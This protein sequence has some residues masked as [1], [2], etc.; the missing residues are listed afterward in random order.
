M[1]VVKWNVF[2]NL[3]WLAQNWHSKEVICDKDTQKLPFEEIIW[4]THKKPFEEQRRPFSS[5]CGL[6]QCLLSE[7]IVT[8]RGLKQFRELHIFPQVD[9]VNVVFTSNVRLF[10]KFSF[11]QLNI[12]SDAAVAAKSVFVQSQRL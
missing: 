7:L 2:T 1:L 5:A 8:K 11:L 3:R 6:F 12:N 10:V 9:N 4:G